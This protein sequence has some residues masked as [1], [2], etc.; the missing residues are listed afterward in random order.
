MNITIL[1]IETT[2][3]RKEGKTDPSPYNKN[4]KIVSVGVKVNS[5]PIQYFFLNHKEKIDQ[6]AAVEIQNILDFTDILVAHNAKFDLSWLYECNF[7]YKNKIYDGMVFEYIISKGQKLGLSLAV[8]AERYSLTPKLDILKE[9]MA[10]GLNTDDVPWQELQEYGEGDIQTTY[11]LYLKQQE[12]IA[13]SPEI[14]SMMPVIEMSMQALPV[15]IQMERDGI[16]IDQEKLKEVEIEY[17]TERDRLEKLMNEMVVEVMG[18]RPINLNSSDHL[19]WVIYS[20]KVNDK[21]EWADIFNI[22]TEL[23]GSVIKKR[24]PRKYPASTFR[25]LVQDNMTTLYRQEASQC[26]DCLGKGT[27]QKTKKDGEPFKKRTSCPKCGGAGFCYTDDKSKVAGFKVQPIDSTYTAAAGFATDKLTIDDLILK[28]KLSQPAQEFLECLKKK[29]A[30]ETYL[31]TFVEGIQ[32]NIKEDGLLHTSFNQCVT[33]TGRLSSSGPNFQNLPRGKTFPVR[34][35][36]ISR[37]KGGFI[38]DADFSQLEFRVAAMLSKCPVALKDIV[39]GVDIHAYTAKILGEAGYPFQKVGDERQES[40][41]H[42]FKPLYGGESGTAAEMAYYKAFLTKYSGIKKW[43]EQLVSNA[44]AV[45]QI[46]IPS[47]RIYSFP[48][49]RRLADRVV[50]KTQIVNYPVQGFA[51]ADITW[52]V[53]LDIYETMCYHS[54]RSKLILQVHDSIVADVHPEEK[55]I[56][57]KIFKD[58]FSKAPQLLKKWFNFETEVPIG[59]EVSMGNNLLEKVAA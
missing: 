37:F 28:G 15:L 46:Q 33:A 52:L 23:R 27:I 14:Q 45:K 36:I 24:Y 5:N 25:E 48:R 4:N 18:D 50:G 13:S 32:K 16:H 58:S 8:C 43:H 39:D 1:D 41:A 59:F 56:M 20:R 55:D 49:A 35:T 9:Y 34:K 40:K 47:G 2:F 30:I 44:C 38:L 57:I 29:N 7:K 21:S 12:L 26:D 22:G 17:R 51:T 54:L 11:E 3:E 10:K 19:S 42:T 6:E 53:L 31:S